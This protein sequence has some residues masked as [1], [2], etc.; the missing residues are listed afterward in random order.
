[1]TFILTSFAFPAL[2][3][4]LALG[5]GALVERLSGLRLPGV[6]LAPLGVA[7]LI[8]VTQFTS[9]FDATAEATPFAAL[10]VGVAGLVV[11]WPRLRRGPIDWA[12]VGA[13]LV[14][15]A[16]VAAPVIMAGRPTLAGYLL[17]TTVG[18]HLAGAEWALEHGRNFD[19]LPPTSWGITLVNYFGTQ[20]PTGGHVLMGGVGKLTFQD[21]I[22]V[23]QPFLSTLIALCAPVL[24][25]LVRSAGVGRVWA[26]V[27]AVV[28][29][30]PAL[31]Y[32]YAQMGAI[33]EI[34]V[35][36]MTLLLGALLV[37]APVLFARGW[38]GLIPFAVVGGGGIGAIGIAFAP[39]L[40]AAVAAGVAVLL[41]VGAARPRALLVPGAALGGLL[42]LCALPT[43]GPLGSSLKLAKSLST[44]NQ[45][46]VNDPGNLLQA[47]HPV[48][49]LGVWINGTH[50]VDPVG[51]DLTRTYLLIGVVALAA[52]LGIAWIVR[53][54]AWGLVLFAALSLVVWAALTQRGTIWTDAKLLVIASPVVLLLAVIGI[55]SLAGT[56]RRAEALIVLALVGGGVL[57]SDAETYHDTNLAPTGRFDELVS[58]GDRF[59][60]DGPALTPD[61]DEFTFYALRDLAPDGPGN[62]YKNPRLGTLRGGGGTGYGQSYDLDSLEPA[63]VQA[64]PTIV[65]R[66][67]PDVSTPPANYRRVFEGDWYEVWRRAGRAPADHV[68][69]SRKADPAGRVACRDLRRVAGDGSRLVLQERTR[70]R[71]IDPRKTKRS[72][73][74]AAAPFG[75]YTSAPGRL[76][77][78]VDAP[79]GRYRLWFR[80][81]FSRTMD[82]LVDGRSVGDVQYETGGEGN[83]AKPVDV[84]LPGGRTKLTLMR[85][86]GGLKPGD[87]SPSRLVLIAVQ[88]V[89]PEPRAERPGS[90]AGAACGERV[91]WVDVLKG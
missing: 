88:P 73:N 90:D 12:A 22:W 34:T 2:L 13:G 77:T 27:G 45:A 19:G 78:A 43:L 57:I 35:L 37:L 71:F 1:M 48:Q 70:T 10:V 7:A 25:F 72:P 79:A 24:Y 42:A 67:R 5:A 21:L 52:V 58:I 50:R 54:R 26:A 9:Y 18:T 20:Y 14:A 29:A 39:W 46:A 76:D 6:L 75:I 87:G 28:A 17:D 44:S 60:G 31:T 11:G 91:D 74:W 16:V 65:M 85:G 81:D 63:A 38:R 64:Y 66:R 41:L 80:G 56:G 69:A 62:A 36:P 49:A 15:Y 86:G 89:A 23:Y 68:P 33:K 40:L 84:T 59:A 61:F 8:V 4:A 3:V 53:S 51:V 83:Y 82:V 55:G 30:V 47:L 32:A